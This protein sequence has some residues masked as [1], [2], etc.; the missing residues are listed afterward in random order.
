M[1]PYVLVVAT[2]IMLETGM[3][4]LGFPN[5][6]YWRTAGVQHQQGKCKDI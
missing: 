3:S 6:P 5:V 4:A 2:T 1:A